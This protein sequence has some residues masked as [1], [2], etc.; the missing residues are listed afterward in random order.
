MENPTEL[1]SVV[2][3]LKEILSEFECCI[4]SEMLTDCNT[5]LEN[6]A[7]RKALW[8]IKD[9]GERSLQTTQGMVHFTH[10]RFIQ[11]ETG[12]TAY[13][14]DATM[15]LEPHVRLSEDVAEKILEKAAEESYRKAGKELG[16]QMQ[17]SAESVM[18][19]VKEVK[20]P[21]R[22]KTEE[23]RKVENLYVEADEDHIALQYKK[24]KG[25]IKR[26]KGHADNGQIVKLVYVHDGHTEGKRREL[27][28]ARYFGGI[29]EGAKG[30]EELWN[31]VKT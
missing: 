19:H 28:N 4:L 3:E 12:E 6:S 18:R 8:Q 30:N 24:E 25:D 11:K 20:I 7:D 10:T 5:A 21:E 15:R 16:E 29:Y 9:R 17:V 1:G 14:L 22:K 31:S 2:V 27:K 13:L 23:K 26:Y